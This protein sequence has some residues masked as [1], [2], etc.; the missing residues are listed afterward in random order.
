M[1]SFVGIWVMVS[2]YELIRVRSTQIHFYLNTPLYY[3]SESTDEVVLYKDSGTQISKKRV[4]KSQIPTLYIHKN[5]RLFAMKELQSS[6]NIKLKE[7]IKQKDIGYV[8]KILVG[9]VS[10]FFAEPRNDLLDGVLQAIDII[11]Q[12][13]I[14]HI[15]DLSKP[16]ENLAYTTAVHSTNVMCL[17]LGY[18]IYNGGDPLSEKTKRI[19]LAGLFHDIGKTLIDDSILNKP[20]KLTDSE[21]D[22]VKQHPENGYNLLKAI[23]VSDPLILNAALEH[24]ENSQGTGYPNARTS[25]SEI[26]TL[27]G[28]IDKY[29]A[30]TS[31]ERFY[32]EKVT[33]YDTLNLLKKEAKHGVDTLSVFNNF[34]HYMASRA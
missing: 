34:V 12:E 1:K 25:V 30:L 5:D 15:H 28:F 10:D 26:G 24:H 31:S 14:E 23:G 16:L 32:K 8:K 4:Q 19:A 33:V 29:E 7:V 22:I 13:F 2:N 17:T 11:L 9:L 27:I 6:Y 18:T 21:Y 3:I 20:D